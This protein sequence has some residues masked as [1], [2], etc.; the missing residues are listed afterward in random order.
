MKAGDPYLEKVKAQIQELERIKKNYRAEDLP[1]LKKV[2]VD[3]EIKRLREFTNRYEKQP[4]LVF[5]NEKVTSDADGSW[6]IGYDKIS[7]KDPTNREIGF[8]SYHIDEDH[9]DL[10]TIGWSKVEEAHRGQGY[11]NE[12]FKKL[13]QDHP[14]IKRIRTS[15]DETNQESFSKALAELVKK[16][17]GFTPPASP[18]LDPKTL[19]R[20]TQKGRESH[21]VL[22]ECCSSY[23]KDLQKSNPKQFDALMEEAL[24]K[25]PAWH[26]REKF[27]FSNLG[28]MKNFN[29][30][31]AKDGSIDFRVEF[32][33]V[34]P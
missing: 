28:D 4:A 18:T 33:A 3:S 19:D 31:G 30:R 5:K 25:T 20:L 22:N 1:A 15:L 8:L 2:D 17:E 7:L 29:F 11:Q 32:D 6:Y 26:T 10:L 16:K 9:R 14:E 27:G 13:F 21:R 24:K 23:L 12:M 34:K